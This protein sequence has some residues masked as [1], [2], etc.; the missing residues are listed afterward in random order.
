MV[1]LIL[2]TDINTDFGD[3]G[4][5]ALLHELANKGEVNILGLGVCVS[6]PDAPYAI[7]AINSTGLTQ[8]VEEDGFQVV[9]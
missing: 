2:D 3:A 5:L 7:Q 8:Q 4:A 9:N 6:N 1:N